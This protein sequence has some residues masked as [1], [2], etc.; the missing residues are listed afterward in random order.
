[1]SYT[2]FSLTQLYCTDARVTP[3]NYEQNVQFSYSTL[4]FIV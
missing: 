1:M 4:A 3:D 2:R